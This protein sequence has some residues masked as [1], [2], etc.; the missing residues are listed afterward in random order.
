MHCK[1]PH[2]PFRLNLYNSVKYHNHIPKTCKE[3]DL[4]LVGYSANIFLLLNT[5]MTL[6]HHN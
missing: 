2:R 4:I 3:I 5:I 1:T 6:M